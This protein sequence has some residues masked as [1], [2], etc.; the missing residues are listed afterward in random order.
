MVGYDALARRVLSSTREVQPRDD[1]IVAIGGNDDLGGA[2]KTDFFLGILTS[3]IL[4]M[5]VNR[6]VKNDKLVS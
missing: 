1:V 3:A 4:A 5:G 6:I 2:N